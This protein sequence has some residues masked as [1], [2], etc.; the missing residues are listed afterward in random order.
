[1]GIV[2]VIGIGAGIVLLS[3]DRIEAAKNLAVTTAVDM[4]LMTLFMRV[5]R[6]GGGLAFLLSM[7]V[8]M[9][10]DNAAFNEAMARER[11]IDDFIHETYPEVLGKYRYCDALFGVV[12][13]GWQ[14]EVKDQAKYQE[15]HDAVDYAVQHPYEFEKQ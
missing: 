14:Y 1:M 7:V 3:D 8:G 10:S 4:S 9:E 11:M 6:V 15:I 13:T 5:G 2:A 12:C